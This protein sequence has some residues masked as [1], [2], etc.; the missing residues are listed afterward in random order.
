MAQIGFKKINHVA[1]LFSNHSNAIS[2]FGKT[3][4]NPQHKINAKRWIFQD[5]KVDY[6]LFVNFPFVLN[7]LFGDTKL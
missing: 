1:I 6:E 2:I 4:Q 3:A 7:L 5:V